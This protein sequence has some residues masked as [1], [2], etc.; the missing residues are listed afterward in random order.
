MLSLRF[1]G[2]YFYMQQ[3]SLYI[4]DGHHQLHLRHIHQNQGGTPV[5]MLHGTIENGKIFYTL[6]GKGLACYLAKQGFDVYVADFRGKGESKPNLKQDAGHG[7]YEA[8]TQDI[9][10]FLDYIEQRCHQPM[11][12]ICHS[13]G[14]VLLASTLAR[15]PQRCRQVAST[16]C[17]GTKRSIYRKTLSKR[18][19]VDL[20][21]NRLAPLLARK[22][23]YIDAV[24]LKFGAD[25]ESLNFLHQS[26]E[27][28]KPGKWCDPVDGFDYHQ[29]AQSINWPRTW[30]ITGAS[31]HLLGYKEDVKAFIEESNAQATFSLLSKSA[32]NAIDYDHINILTHPYA[33]DDHFPEVARW[34][35]QEE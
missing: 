17:F 31:D 24:K 15:Y 35:A 13:W 29:A 12:L 10:L 22:K 3:E 32:G 20:L 9:P 16:L 19:T 27:W 33:I 25:N 4:Q 28:V 7:Q 18:W 14:G 11:H 2:F 26:I 30:H 5:L 21:W 1:I 8:I 34:L 6:S 23:G